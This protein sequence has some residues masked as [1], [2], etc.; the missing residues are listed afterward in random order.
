M[1]PEYSHPRCEAAPRH[2]VT[3]RSGADGQRSSS[4]NVRS[5]RRTGSPARDPGVERGRD[6]GAKATDVG[7][8]WIRMRPSPSPSRIAARR[9]CSCGISA[10]RGGIR[11]PGC[12]GRLPRPRLRDDGGRS[13]SRGYQWCRRGS[14]WRPWPKVI[15]D[16]TSLPIVSGARPSGGRLGGPDLVV[17]ADCLRLRAGGAWSAYHAQRL[18]RYRGAYDA[19]RDLEEADG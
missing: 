3:V 5:C 7:R 16:A 17:A 12:Q 1:E 13:R 14:R 9:S 4:R 8:R 11:R 2:P 6:P 15:S 19:L 18:D 10:V